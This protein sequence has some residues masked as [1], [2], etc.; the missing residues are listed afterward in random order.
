MNTRDYLKEYARVVRG[1]DPTTVDGMVE[2]IVR[3]YQ[4][5][6]TVFCFGNGG[7]AANASHFAADLPKLTAP[8]RDAPRIKAVALNDTV[9]ATTAIANDYGFEEVFEEQLRTFMRPGDVLIG[10]ST[11][12]SS[13]NVLRAIDYGR[14]T[15]AT[16]IG[17]TGRNGGEL[18]RRAHHVL[19][20]DSTSV[21]Q[22]EDASMVVAHLLCLGVR[23][24]RALVDVTANRVTPLDVA[25]APRATASRGRR[26][27]ALRRA[28]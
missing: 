27:A 13:P 25:P 1:I 11:S 17:I 12:G 28:V 5:D 6:G 19:M 24:R 21:Q 7:S 2:A 4:H 20:L 18:G 15:G 8:G 14:R 9:S 23:A 26:T 22:V 16:T 3:A 10:F